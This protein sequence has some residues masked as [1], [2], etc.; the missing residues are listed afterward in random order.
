MR[1]SEQYRDET[2]RQISLTHTQTGI[3]GRLR[4][5]LLDPILVCYSRHR[6]L[7][8][9]PAQRPLSQLDYCLTT[10]WAS[11]ILSRLEEVAEVQEKMR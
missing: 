8:P 1:P 10:P 9:L 4:P 2:Q 11:T 5:Q 6:Y 7:L 3:T